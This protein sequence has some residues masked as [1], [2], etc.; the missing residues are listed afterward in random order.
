MSDIRSNKIFICNI[1][2]DVNKYNKQFQH[3]ILPSNTSMSINTRPESTKYDERVFKRECQTEPYVFMENNL[4]TKPALYN[5]SIHTETTLRN[6]V[7]KNNECNYN[8]YVPST[9]SD[10]YKLNVPYEKQYGKH[11]LLFEIPHFSSSCTAPVASAQAFNNFTREQ[12]N[13]VKK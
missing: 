8:S 1:D 2:S 11:D 4:N 7:A 10:L 9:E 12:R 6:T 13:I 3:S 5:E